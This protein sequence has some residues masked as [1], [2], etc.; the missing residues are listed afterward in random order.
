MNVRSLRLKA[1]LTQVQLA[2]LME[3]DQSAVSL[4]ETGKHAPRA[5]DYKRLAKALGVTVD[6]LLREE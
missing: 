5:K 4:W 3:I 1:G 6:E 2:K